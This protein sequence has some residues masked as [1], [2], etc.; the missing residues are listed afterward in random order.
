MI[1][2]ITWLIYKPKI[3]ATLLS[4]KDNNLENFNISSNDG[5]SSSIFTFG[6]YGDS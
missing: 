6:D 5:A 3:T 2:M 1:S 4:D